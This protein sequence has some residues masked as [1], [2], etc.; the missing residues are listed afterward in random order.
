MA[1]V[2]RLREFPCPGKDTGRGLQMRDRAVIVGT[3][4]AK[5]SGAMKDGVIPILA[6]LLSHNQN[7]PGNYEENS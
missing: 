2:Q 7:G 3:M 6:A 4:K 5:L 1:W